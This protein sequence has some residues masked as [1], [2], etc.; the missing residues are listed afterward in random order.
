MVWINLFGIVYSLLQIGLAIQAKDP[1][2]LFLHLFVFLT[3]VFFFKDIY[4]K[5]R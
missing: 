4:G 2:A 1:K 5:R 3:L